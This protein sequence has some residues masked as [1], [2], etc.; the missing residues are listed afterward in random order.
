MCF[1]DRIV[2]QILMSSDR[3]FDNLARLVPEMEAAL[4]KLRDEW[5]P[6]S[7]PATV[8][9]CDLAAEFANIF[10]GLEDN[11]VRTIRGLC[12]EALVNGTEEEQAGF[13]TGFLEALQHADDRR[14][15]D[16]SRVSALLGSESR[17]HCRAMDSFWCC[18]TRGL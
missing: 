12:E 14:D 3:Y 10:N 4:I 17:R 9:G 5:A 16:F 6:C 8:A 1:G 13:S 7:V 2:R 11:V 15:F 18:R